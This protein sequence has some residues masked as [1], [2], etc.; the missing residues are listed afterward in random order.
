MTPSSRPRHPAWMAATAAQS[1]PS[2]PYRA[3]GTQS[4][5]LTASVAR[6]IDV[7]AASAQ[8]PR[9]SPGRRTS[10]TRVPWTC[11]RTVTLLGADPSMGAQ[12]PSERSVTEIRTKLFPQRRR[13]VSIRSA[14]RCGLS[15]RAAP[16]GVR[17]RR[18]C[19]AVWSDCDVTQ[20]S[21]QEAGHVERLV[22]LVEVAE[23]VSH[24]AGLLRGCV[25]AQRSTSRAARS[26]SVESCSDDRYTDLFPE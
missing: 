14:R 3:I 18:R 8:A 22:V 21:P 6:G 11:R 23:R 16:L 4:A 13:R 1:A 9:C 7:H 17:D 24:I 15:S 26:I 19:A 10:T 12:S 2:V 25:V 5:V 20:A